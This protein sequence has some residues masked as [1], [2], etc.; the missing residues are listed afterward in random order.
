MKSAQEV[1]SICKV[2]QSEC[3][4]CSVYRVTKYS[5]KVFLTWS[6]E[7]LQYLVSTV[8]LKDYFKHILYGV[9]KIVLKEWMWNCYYIHEGK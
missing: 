7:S 2:P 4:L 3:M 6:S 8:A 9:P 1:L 5:D